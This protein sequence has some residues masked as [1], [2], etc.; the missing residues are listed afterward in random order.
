MEALA[1][2]LWP[3][4]EGDV[5]KDALRVALHRLRKLLG[6]EQSVEV[7]DGRV[8]LAANWCWIDAVAL[9]RVFDGTARNGTA[10]VAQVLHLYRGH[11]LPG[12]AEHPWVLAYRER[13]RSK[14]LRF[15]R[16]TALALETS[17][18]IESAIDLYQRAIEV[19]PLAESIY[20]R[21]MGS[22][23]RIGRRAE[24]LD[25]YRRC[26]QMLSVVLGIKP[27]TD[28]E[29]LHASLQSDSRG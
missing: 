8:A 12:D 29:A 23:A 1:G 20:R 2:A 19:E 26:R 5:A 22:Y 3:D 15:V 25:A 18:E 6:G 27:S 24:A 17:G 16:S 4:T 10:P 13:L 21:L 28:T 14:F 7:S 9:E 11:L